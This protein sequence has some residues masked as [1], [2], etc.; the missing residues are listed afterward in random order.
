MPVLTR[1]LEYSTKGNSEIIDITDDVI[2]SVGGSGI[3]NGTVTV[4][5]AGSTVA[6]TT[7]E[8]EPGLIHDLQQALERI[9]PQNI[10]YKHN[11]RWHDGNGHSHV[12]AS[13]LGQSESFP[14]I[15]GR[16]LLGTWQQIIFIDLDNKARSRKLVV[17]IVG[18]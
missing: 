2:R 15:D 1:Y 16:L 8:Y 14:L 12:R 7:L 13:F 5:A 17:Q 3:G 11:E 18:E 10:E 6:V 9:A 4:F